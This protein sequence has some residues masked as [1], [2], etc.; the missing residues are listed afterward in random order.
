LPAGFGKVRLKRFWRGARDFLETINKDKNMTIQLSKNLLLSV[1]GLILFAALAAGAYFFMPEQ[2]KS[3]TMKPE[4][5][6][7]KAIDY[8][9]QNMLSDGITASFKDS[10]EANGLYN[11]KL[12]V[13]GKDYDAYV[14]KDGA[15]FFAEG[16]P[17]A[18]ILDKKL[19]E[20]K[21][22]AEVVKSDKPE[23]NVFVMSYCP[24]GLQA[25]KMYLPVYDLLKDKASLSVNFVNYA[26]HGKK[27]IDENLRQY[28]IEKEQT[29]KY[30]TYLKCFTTAK[31][32]ADGAAEY[33][34]CL[35][36]AGIDEAK[37]SAC[38]SSTDS[39][40]KV[41]ADFNDK[42]TWVSGQFPKFAVEDALNTQ[43]G[44][45]G[46]PTIVINGKDASE[47]LSARSPEKFKQLICAAF[48]TQ[49]EE[50][51]TVLSEDQP[52]TG[53]DTGVSASDTASGGCG[54]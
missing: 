3:K 9:N 30:S 45:Q 31:T 48:N 46:S 39:E 41:T 10:K 1:G 42:N 52:A 6:A 7:Q 16:I 26:M 37:L 13:Q 44:V 21:A 36:S 49:P 53:F 15:L 20:E 29:D 4:A 18:I 11:F 43:Y 22:A 27:E 8:V 54:G 24:Y 38:V 47:S 23:V 28:C 50:C 34:G 25:Q 40:F 35:A 5:A 12:T 51:K 33:K 19:E 32:D 17:Q 2:F 14:T